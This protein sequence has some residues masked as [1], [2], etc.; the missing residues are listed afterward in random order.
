MSEIITDFNFISGSSLKTMPSEE[1]KRWINDLA[2]KYENDIDSPELFLEIEKFK[3]QASTL[4]GS[5]QSA[6]QFDLLKFI[7]HYTLQDFYHNLDVALRIFL[8]IPVTTTTC[9]RSFSKLKIIK[10]YLRSTMNQN[11]LTSMT[12]LSIEKCLVDQLSFD[13]VID[14]FAS[15]KARKVKF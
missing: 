7:H 3:F 5:F 2:L 6:T 11:C 13:D 1:I 15:I 8:T 12:I 9:E 14:D 4:M 10:N